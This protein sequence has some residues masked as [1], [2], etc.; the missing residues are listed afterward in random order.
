MKISELVEMLE[1]AK[2]RFGDVD[3]RICTGY[4]ESEEPSSYSVVVNENGWTR[5]ISPDEADGK[6]VVRIEIE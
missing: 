4:G 5:D 2:A 1:T 3:V 6:R